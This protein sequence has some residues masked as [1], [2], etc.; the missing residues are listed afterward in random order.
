MALKKDFTL[1]A[2]NQDVVV[3]DAYLK[4]MHVS[5]NKT[6]LQVIVGVFQEKDGNLLEKVDTSFSPKMNAVNFI[7]QAYEHLK[8]QPEFAGAEDC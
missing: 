8:T 3:K 2:Y 5:G 4:V 1:R 7:Q 6:T